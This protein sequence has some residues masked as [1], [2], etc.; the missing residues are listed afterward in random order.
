MVNFLMIY[1][2]LEQFQILPLI[3]LPFFSFDFSVTN[4][5]ILSVLSLGSFLF[6][7]SLVGTNPYLVPTRWQYGLES[8]Y[9][10][11]GGIVEDNLGKNGVA[12]A[13]FVLIL[14][15]F[16]LVS[17]VAGLVPYSFTTTSHLVVTLA[18]ALTVFGGVNIISIKKHKLHMLS[19]FLPGG[20]NLVL[21]L[22]LVP[23][24]AV[25]YIFKPISLAVRLFANIIAGHTL[26]KVIGGFAWAMIG[27][28]TLLLGLHLVPLIVLVLL[29]GLE[30]GVAVIQAYVFTILTCIYLHDGIHLH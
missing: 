5:T 21:A 7:N 29:V 14:F 8:L 17:N 4:A 11:I 20:T 15:C 9:T 22:L 13:P 2:P 26:L 24:E 3:S 10:A 6:L 18:L 1:S 16:V 28:G 23:I 12:Y 19:V 30:L 25:S 27:G